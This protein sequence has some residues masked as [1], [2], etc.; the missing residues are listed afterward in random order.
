MMSQI[1]GDIVC[2]TKNIDQDRFKIIEEAKRKQSESESEDS[3][4][5]SV[6]EDGE[7]REVSLNDTQK[8]RT[9]KT[10]SKVKLTITDIQVSEGTLILS[11]DLI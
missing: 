1:E 2:I 10:G 8:G 3:D 11:C 4:E 9:M 5:D 7:S 6:F